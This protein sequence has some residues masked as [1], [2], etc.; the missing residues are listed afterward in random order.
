M[1][2]TLSSTI[3][4]QRSRKK[5]YVGRMKTKPNVTEILVENIRSLMK[6]TKTTKPM[7]AKKSGV[8]ERMIA[9]IL[10]KQRTPTV[11]I[12][13]SLASAFG[14][15]GWQLMV[16]GIKPEIAKS[17]D[18]LISRYSEMTP[19]G[20]EYLDRVAEQESKYNGRSKT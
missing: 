20:R 7:L 16:P 8:S 11:D 2:H 1:V 12:A 5:R 10:A 18:S 9:Y 14:L 4:H 3:V 13:E 17:T 15:R 6:E 19:E